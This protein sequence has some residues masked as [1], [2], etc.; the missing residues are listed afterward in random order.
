MRVLI[1]LLL[2]L[3][4]TL[5]SLAVPGAVAAQTT[6][7]TFPQTNFAVADIGDTRFLSEFRRFGGVD[8]LGYP[9]SN[10]FVT[11]GFTYQMFQRGALQWR[12]EAGQAVLANVMDWLS[13]A[14]RDPYL[15]TLGIP[16]PLPDAGGAWQQVVAERE[17]WLTEPAIAAAYRQGGGYNRFGLPASR[18]ERS[19]PFVV[20]RFQRYAFQLWVEGVP[21]MPAAGSVVGVLAG[22]LFKQAGLLPATASTP[23]AQSACISNPASAFKST[24]VDIVRYRL[25]SLAFEQIGLEVTVRNNCPEAREVRFSARAAAP[26]APLAALGALKA[27][28][29]GPFEEKGLVYDWANPDGTYPAIPVNANVTFRWNWHRQGAPETEQQCLEVGAQQCLP[30]DPWLRSTV[31]DLLAV[32]DGANL[33]RAAANYGVNIRRAELSPGYLGSYRPF[34]KVITLTKALD[35]YSEF[36]RANVLSHELSHVSD[37][38][39]NR[40]I[41]DQKGCLES[42][43]RAFRRSGEVWYGLWGGALPEPPRNGMQARFNDIAKSARNDPAKLRAAIASSYDEACAD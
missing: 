15:A 12:P 24:D 40:D 14:A 9:I 16:A 32:P 18:P 22:D 31:Q 13:D 42:E 36:E 37:V 1:S 43:E 11:D 30:T 34:T 2:A 25:V 28:N 29:L 35:A 38:I 41:W 39:E 21:G 20:Q 8:A 33:L 19:G 3:V 23:G 17:S 4:V 6:S 10:P 5:S 27:V 7:Q 26:G